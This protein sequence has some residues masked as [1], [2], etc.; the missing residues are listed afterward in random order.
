MYVMC[1]VIDNYILLQKK[2]YIQLILSKTKL[3]T[4][5]KVTL[6]VNVYILV[7]AIFAKLNRIYN[8]YKNLNTHLPKR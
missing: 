7:D 3:S 8:F 1:K 2:L 5:I 6:H 4:V